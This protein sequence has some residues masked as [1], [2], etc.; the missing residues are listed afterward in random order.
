MNP[1][2]NV[3]INLSEWVFTELN[4]LTLTF[5]PFD[6]RPDFSYVGVILVTNPLDWLFIVIYALSSLPTV[7]PPVERTL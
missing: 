3:T 5:A 4:I 1:N 7:C 6:F 2:M